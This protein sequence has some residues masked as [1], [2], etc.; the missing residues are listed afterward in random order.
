MNL[1]QPGQYLTFVL[2]G[3]SYGVAIGTVR[4][5]NQ[6]LDITP[7]PQTPS[8]VAGVMNLRG[9]VVPVVN[10]RLKFGMEDLAFT[11]QTC[12]IVVETDGGHVGMIVDR[13]SGV[14]DFKADQ[15]EASPTLG[16]ETKMSYIIGMGKIERQVVVLVDIQKALSKAE[17]TRLE[18]IAAPPQ[19]LA[20]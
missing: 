3:Q 5:I 16:E 10:L 17:L 11:K 7:V 15:I 13:V 20:A 19:K 14:A 6:V 18:Q 4:E 12:I 1:A 2:K 9:K 8:F